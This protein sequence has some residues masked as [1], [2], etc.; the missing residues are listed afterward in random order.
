MF[1]VVQQ[2]VCRMYWSPPDYQLDQGH[3]IMISRLFRIGLLSAAISGTAMGCTTTLYVTNYPGFFTNT[4][5]Y[6]SM[7]VAA[8]ENSVEPGRYT[9]QLNADIVNGLVNNGFYRVVDYTRE[10]MS[11]SQVLASLRETNS[12]DLVV[13]STLSNYGE[14]HSKRIETRTETN[15]IYKTD[16]EGYTIYDDNG[17]PVIDHIEE[18][19][20]DYPVFERT[21][22]ADMFVNVV[23]VGSGNIVYNSTR[24]GSCYEE[25]ENPHHMS[26]P[27][28]ARWCAIDRAVSSE[29]YQI[30]PTSEAIR[31]REKDV[32][33]IYRYDE[34]DGWTESTKF[35]PGDVMKLQFWFPNS[36]YYNTFRFDIVYGRDDTVVISDAIYWEGNVQTFE[37]EISS[38]AESLNGEDEFRVRLLNNNHVAISKDIKIK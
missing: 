30:C 16:E 6:E 32:L 20:V 31:V 19:Q 4:S 10:D 22:Y 33:Q 27:N 21:S 35:Y 24:H 25:A 3:I 8:V 11:D 36:A 23:E 9:R 29:I 13:F 7:A 18:Y 1:F 38:I 2:S 12:S 15:T 26:P 28:S 34:K 17:N 5:T 37:Y 14:E